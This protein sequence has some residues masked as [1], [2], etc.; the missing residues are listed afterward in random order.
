MDRDEI[1]GFEVVSSEKAYKRLHE[2]LIKS[3]ALE[4]LLNEKFYDPNEISDKEVRSKAVD[5][6]KH[7]LECREK[8]Y[9]SVGYGYDYRFE[10]DEVAGSALVH[11]SV[12]HMAFFRKEKEFGMSFKDEMD[13]DD[14]G[15]DIIVAS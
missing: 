2:K 5:F 1:A 10:D 12:V 6:F 3:Y 13:E 8:K 11:E 7:V 14:I 9:K 15:D 4:A